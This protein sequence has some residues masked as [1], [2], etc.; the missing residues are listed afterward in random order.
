MLDFPRCANRYASA[1]ASGFSLLEVLISLVIVAVGLLGIA[2]LMSN[3]LKSNDSAAMRTQATAQAYNI[4]D[5]MRANMTGVFAGNYVVGMPSSAAT[6]ALPSTCTGAACSS[7]ALATYDIGQ[8]EYE[9][10]KLLPQGRGSISIT[11]V[12]TGATYTVTVR[13]ND[14]RAEQALSSAPP[15]TSFNLVVS[16]SF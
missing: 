15:A 12:P 3:T 16:S 8:W 14:T 1:H 5:R 11:P 10:A 13:W 4:I 6:G 7:P 9:L 2:G